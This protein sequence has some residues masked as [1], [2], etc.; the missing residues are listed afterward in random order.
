MQRMSQGWG[1][2]GRLESLLGTLNLYKR[3]AWKNRR[4]QCSSLRRGHRF[5]F[6]ANRS[7]FHEGQTQKHEVVTQPDKQQ[8][9]P[10][11]LEEMETT[12]PTPQGELPDA[13]EQA[14]AHQSQRV[15]GGH[16]E[17]EVG[18]EEPSKEASPQP[19][20]NGHYDEDRQ[21]GGVKTNGHAKAAAPGAKG[22][23]QK[24]KKKKKDRPQQWAKQAALEAERKAR[25]ALEASEAA[26]Q[27]WT[28]T[29]FFPFPF[30]PATKQHGQAE[31]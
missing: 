25:E 17:E 29:Q 10:E 14:L 31:H 7:F 2:P 5:V 21:E 28:L 12:H 6:Q 24:K 22:K 13:L 27:V 4:Q 26:N 19:E 20:E 18:S 16:V 3:V 15:G 9:E 8:P 1:P 23:K 30:L 11:S